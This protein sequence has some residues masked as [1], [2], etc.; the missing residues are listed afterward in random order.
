MSLSAGNTC[1]GGIGRCI[2]TGTRQGL[3][4]YLFER[5]G[6]I[7]LARESARDALAEARATGVDVILHCAFNAQRETL[8]SSLGS[9]LAD[10]LSLTRELLSLPHRVFVYVSSV[11]V[12]PKDGRLHTEDED[13]VIGSGQNLYG[14]MKLLAECVVREALGH[15]PRAPRYL[16][17][18]PGSLLGLYARRGALRR[19]VEDDR[20]AVSL[21]SSSTFN[22]VSYRDLATFLEQAIRGELQGTYNVCASSNMTLADAARAVGKDVRFGEAAYHVGNICNRK[23]VKIAPYFDKSSTDVLRGYQEELRG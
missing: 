15:R 9:Q 11:D 22:C 7:A 4:R 8:L 1:A 12:Y 23:I 20:P 16:I 2:V 14:I 3:G 18:R 6:G 19:I 10:N 5:F 17:V 21:A 13:I